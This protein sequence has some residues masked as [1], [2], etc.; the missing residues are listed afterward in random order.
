MGKPRQGRAYHHRFIADYGIITIE[1]NNIEALQSNT[2]GTFN[3]VFQKAKQSLS[4]KNY[5]IY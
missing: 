1:I 2:I 3:A 4:A 5:K